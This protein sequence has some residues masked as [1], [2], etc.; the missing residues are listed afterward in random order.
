MTV[1]HHTPVKQASIKNLPGPWGHS[2]ALCPWPGHCLSPTLH[3]SQD[4]ICSP[5]GYQPHLSE[6]T[7]GPVSSLVL[8][9]SPFVP[10]CRLWLHTGPGSLLTMSGAVEG[11]HNEPHGTMC[12][13]WRQAWLSLGSTTP[14]EPPTC[15]APWH[16]YKIHK[17]DL[18]YAFPDL[19]LQLRK[20][21]LLSKQLQQGLHH[22]FGKAGPDVYT[23]TFLSS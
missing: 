22:S 8:V 11:P 17:V 7:A 10:V 16:N 20:H 21:T 3:M 4:P 15:T 14:R 12:H 13:A 2:Q 5:W 1:L 9:P 18:I 6:A 23:D 19:I